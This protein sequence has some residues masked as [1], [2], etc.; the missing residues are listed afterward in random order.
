[1]AAAL[2]DLDGT[3]FLW[4]TETFLPGAYAELQRFQQAGN[5]LI[6]VTQR[7]SEN[8]KDPLS[9]VEL[10]L[11]RV[12]PGCTVIFGVSSPRIL[13]NDAGAIAINHPQNAPWHYDLLGILTSPH[14]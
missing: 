7:D 12:F 5:Q 14:L 6:F 8:W 11:K 9:R 3:T 13:I 1:M 10:F 4:S 2:I